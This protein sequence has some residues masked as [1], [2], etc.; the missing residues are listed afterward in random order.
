MAQEQKRRNPKEI[1]IPNIKK[2]SS[3]KS[4]TI[5]NLGKNYLKIISYDKDQNVK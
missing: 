3:I 5:T 4:Y 2:I 1:K